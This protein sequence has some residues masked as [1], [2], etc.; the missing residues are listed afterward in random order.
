MSPKEIVTRDLLRTTYD[1]TS[2]L[3]DGY[4]DLHSTTAAAAAV[5]YAR[6][7]DHDRCCS[8]SNCSRRRKTATLT[9]EEIDIL[10]FL[11]GLIMSVGSVHYF[12][13]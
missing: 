9:L 10:T 1:S 6:S 13:R 2:W 3:A 7:R 5:S 11:S 12:R 4:Y 8:Y